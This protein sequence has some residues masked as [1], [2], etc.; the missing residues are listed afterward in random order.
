MKRIALHTMLVVALGLGGPQL[1]AHDSKFPHAHLGSTIAPDYKAFAGIWYQNI[2]YANTPGVDA[3]QQDLDIYTLDLPLTNAPV[4]IYVHGGGG[5][6]GDKAWSMD[7][8]LKPAY[9]I[10]KEGMIFVSINYRLGK[11]G[12]FPNAHQDIA[13][14][15]AWVHDNIAQFGGNPDQIILS[16]LKIDDPHRYLREDQSSSMASVAESTPP[17]NSSSDS[18]GDA[19][20][21]ASKLSSSLLVPSKSR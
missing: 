19:N 1:L 17:Q 8:N 9:F 2:R 14:A 18:I 21:A 20:P 3:N 6:R 12:G 10:A 16:C 11:D 4:M 5:D 7:L 13:S 15:V